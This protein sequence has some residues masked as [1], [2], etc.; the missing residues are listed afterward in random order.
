MHKRALTILLIG[1]ALAGC[2]SAPDG[3]LVASKP[4]D[5]MDTP[6]WC[7]FYNQYLAKNTVSEAARRKD[8]ELMRQRGCAPELIPAR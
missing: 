7:T 4:I 1:L 8:I 5:K 3:V 2:Q 6:E